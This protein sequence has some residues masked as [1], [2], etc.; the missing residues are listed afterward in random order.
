MGSPPRGGEFWTNRLLAKEANIPVATVNRVLQRAALRIPNGRFYRVALDAKRLLLGYYLDPPVRLVAV[1]RCG[2]ENCVHEDTTRL[3][4]AIVQLT[5]AILAVEGILWN[6][7]RDSGRPES[8][9][10][11]LRS[12]SKISA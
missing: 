9:A 1:R 11:F 8:L 6:A 3:R 4:R 12:L 2:P 5:D 7:A 10:R